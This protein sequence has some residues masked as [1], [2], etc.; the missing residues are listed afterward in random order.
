MTN[1]LYIGGSPCSGKS[2]VT[3]MISKKYGFYYFKVDDFLDEYMMKGKVRSKPICSKLHDMTPEQIWMR[4][5]EEQ[6]VEEIQIYR[7]IFEFIL[8]DLSKINSEGTIITEGAALL[9]ELMDQITVDKKQYISITPTADFQVSHYKERPW[10]PHILEGCQD[11]EKAFENWMNRDI[12]FAREVEKQC[13]KT[14]YG[15]LVN[16]G[17]RQP[18]EIFDLVCDNFKLT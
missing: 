4:S 6:C 7:E 9:P 1:V 16:D 8:A 17:T 15:S 11:K 10:V 5:P 12:L 14:G 3:E 2:T 18:V 13:R